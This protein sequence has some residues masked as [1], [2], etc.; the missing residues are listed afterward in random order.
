MLPL[1]L[2]KSECC[3][4]ISKLLTLKSKIKPYNSKQLRSSL[5][6]QMKMRAQ[7]PLLPLTKSERC[8]AI[9]ELQ[10]QMLQEKLRN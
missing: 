7:V 5:E 8:K 2:T 10:E 4:A 6:K 3:K 9:S 1:P